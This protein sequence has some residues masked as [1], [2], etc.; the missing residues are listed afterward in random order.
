MLD[1]T[2]VIYM[3]DNGYHLGQWCVAFDKMLPYETDV[4]VPF[5]MRGPGIKS[6]SV[7]ASLIGNTDVFPTI[8]ALAQ[9]DIQTEVDGE[10]FAPIVITEDNDY[11]EPHSMKGTLREAFLMEYMNMGESELFGYQ[12]EWYNDGSAGVSGG[13]R[14]APATMHGRESY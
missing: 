11:F 6:K 10:S 8:M 1:N 2:Y 7:V 5:F 3:S 14:T 12:T 13:S 4:R 9:K